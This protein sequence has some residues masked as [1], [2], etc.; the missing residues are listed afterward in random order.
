M[1]TD[2]ADSYRKARNHIEKIVNDTISDRDYGRAVKQ[3]AFIS[4][5]LP[6]DIE[7]YQEIIKYHKTQKVIEFRLK[8]DYRSFKDGN[9]VAHKRLICEALLRSLQMLSES[10]IKNFDHVQLKDDFLEIARTNQWL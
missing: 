9:E 8:I 2:V 5:L 1:H 7:G 10:N 6:S 4:I 3:W